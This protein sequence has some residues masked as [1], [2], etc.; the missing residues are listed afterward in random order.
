ML[1]KCDGEPDRPTLIICTN[2]KGNPT[3][4]EA[5]A[6]LAGTRLADATQALVGCDDVAIV[7][8]R[9]LANCSRGPSVA[10]RHAGAWSYIFGGVDP[11]GDAGSL[12]EGARLLAGAPDG[13]MPWRG[14]PDCLKRGLIAR[15]P[16]LDFTGDPA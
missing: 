7:R 2:C 12:I 14:R 9:C 10:M 1:E 13:L 6:P 15:I 5:G 4:S 8:V 3:T 11:D 16:P